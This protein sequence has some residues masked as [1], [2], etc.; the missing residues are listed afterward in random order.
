MTS[1]FKHSRMTRASHYPHTDP[2][3]SLSSVAFVLS[4][5]LLS[6]PWWSAPVQGHMKGMYATK[7]EAA[8]RAAELKCKGVFAMDTMW[9]PCANERAFHEALQKEQ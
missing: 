8:K 4:G 6:V 1:W 2:M 5:L 9:M 3:A 7:E